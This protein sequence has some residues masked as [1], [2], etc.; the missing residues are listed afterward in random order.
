MDLPVSTF[1]VL[2]EK[3]ESPVFDYANMV[4]AQMEG[5]VVIMEWQA[6]SG[7]PHHTTAAIRKR[8]AVQ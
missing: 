1:D 5:E 7:S 3:A 6:G 8:P 2:L 4:R